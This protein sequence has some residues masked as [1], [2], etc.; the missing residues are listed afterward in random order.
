MPD[1]TLEYAKSARRR[2][3][4]L[5]VAGAGMAAHLP[6]VLAAATTLPVISAYPWLRAR[7]MVPM[8]STPSSRCRP[9]FRWPPWPSMGPGMPPILPARSWRSAMILLPDGLMSGER[10]RVGS[11]WS[12]TMSSVS[13][14]PVPL[15]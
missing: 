12:A 1:E 5:L 13:Y 8:P 6:G 7:S 9:G 3:L 11:C 4:R 15:R 10:W 2:G 14:L